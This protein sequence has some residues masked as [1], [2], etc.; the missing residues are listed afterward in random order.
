MDVDTYC[1]HL[2]SRDLINN[3]VITEAGGLLGR[4]RGFKFNDDTGKVSSLIIGLK[5]IPLI[6]EQ[7]ISTYELPIGEIVL[8]RP[9]STDCV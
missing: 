5:R 8:H 7:A 9:E 6:P 4:V 2:C 1:G 3:E